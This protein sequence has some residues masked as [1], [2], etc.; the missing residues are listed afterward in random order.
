MDEWVMWGGVKTCAGLAAVGPAGLFSRW[1]ST[2]E[3]IYNVGVVVWILALVL[4]VGLLF[5]EGMRRARRS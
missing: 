3:D 5:A 1:C 2:P 4:L